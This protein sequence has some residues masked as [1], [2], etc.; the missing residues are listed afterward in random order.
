MKIP[1]FLKKNE[2]EN[3]MIDVSDPLDIDA[4]K[5]RIVEYKLELETIRR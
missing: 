1:S 5:H 3:L 4:G 2:S